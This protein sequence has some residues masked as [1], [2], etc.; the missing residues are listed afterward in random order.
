M[1]GSES[2]HAVEIANYVIATIYE[3]AYIFLIASI[4]LRVVSLREDVFIW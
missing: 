4:D 2:I 3:G 1:V